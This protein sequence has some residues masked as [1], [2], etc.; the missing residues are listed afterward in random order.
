M[1]DFKGITMKLLT[2]A[3]IKDA[4]VDLASLRL[5]YSTY[6]FLV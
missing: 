1:V 2:G 4:L 6:Y 3:A 5:I